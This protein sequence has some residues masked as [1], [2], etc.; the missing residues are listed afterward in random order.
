MTEQSRIWKVKENGMS[1]RCLRYDIMVSGCTHHLDCK[2]CEYAK[3]EAKN[4]TNIP[5]KRRKKSPT[6]DISDPIT[7]KKRGS[8]GPN[9]G[10]YR[11]I[12]TEKPA[13]ISKTG[14]KRGV[15]GG[16]GSTHQE[17]LFR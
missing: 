13:K 9:G 6:S 16:S 3:K 1:R 14:D 5:E 2:D 17:K 4:A 8:K 12:C 15:R 10:L 11:P 7:V